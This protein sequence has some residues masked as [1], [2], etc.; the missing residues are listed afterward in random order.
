MPAVHDDDSFD[1][2]AALADC[3]RGD[4]EA[5]Q[6]IYR[7]E[8]RRLLGVALRIVRQRALAEDVLHDAFVQVWTRAASFDPAR[9]AG[10]G[11]IYS[12]V[13]HRALNAVRDGAREVRPDEDAMEALHTDAALAAHHDRADAFERQV[14]LGR[15]GACLEGLEPARRDCI[16]HAYLDGCT[17]GEIATR[18]G[19]PLGTVKAWIRRGL[20]ALRECL[21]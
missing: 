11:W 3:A 15:L 10:R 21:R 18:V 9:G 7:H 20:L 12:I 14:L 4:Q 17:H 2:D 19:A 6:R 13:R 16:L 5:L 8:S 1:H